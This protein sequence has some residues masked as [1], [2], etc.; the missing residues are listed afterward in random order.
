MAFIVIVP[1]KR[2]EEGRTI[3]AVF[4]TKLNELFRRCLFTQHG[5]SRVT[6]YEFN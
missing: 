3:Q 2:K 5:D 6:R 4:L 1:R